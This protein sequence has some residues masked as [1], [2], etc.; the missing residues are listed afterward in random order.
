MT[1]FQNLIDACR[2]QWLMTGQPDKVNVLHAPYTALDDELVLRY[3]NQGINPGTRLGIGLEEFHVLSISGSTA[4]ATVTVIPA[5]NGSTSANHSAGD[6]VRI[7]P[8]FSDWRIS[9]AI[10]DCLASLTSEGL[11]RIQ[12]LEFNYTP[13]KSGYNISAADLID[14]WRVTFD[15]PGPQRDWPRLG[16]RDWFL[17]NNPDETDFPGGR[18]LIL[19]VAGYPGFPV[20][21]SYRAFIGTLVNLADDVQATTGL[22]PS[23]HE[24]PPLG[25]AI[26]LLSGR[27]VKRTFLDQQPEPRRSDEV[28]PGAA[29]NAMLPIMQAYRE[30]IVREVTLLHRLYP[31]VV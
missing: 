16:P 30:A 31:Q 23:A 25:A 3:P 12:D 24:I 19:R 28:P 1:T 20:R 18:S 9:R 26:R 27:D 8:Q 4:E 29:T 7:S 21:V 14:I 22:L 17:D 5:Y 2:D 15:Y 10:K 13:A 6:L 11:F